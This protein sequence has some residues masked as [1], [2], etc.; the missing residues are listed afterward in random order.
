MIKNVLGKLDTQEESLLHLGD[1][2]LAEFLIATIFD[3]LTYREPLKGCSQV[4]RIS[5]A[6]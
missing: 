3:F 4:E 6:S 2:F 1:G 5:Q